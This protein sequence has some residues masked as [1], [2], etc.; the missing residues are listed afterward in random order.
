M[1]QVFLQVAVA[2][3]DHEH[4]RRASLDR[5]G[6]IDLASAPGQWVLRR[7]IPVGR[8]EQRRPLDVRVVVGTARRDVEQADVEF[9]KQVDEPVRVRKIVFDRIVRTP[10]ESV[11]VR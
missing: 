1:R 3:T 7:L 6:R 9:A 11:A 5:G 4:V 2:R 10:S 8:R